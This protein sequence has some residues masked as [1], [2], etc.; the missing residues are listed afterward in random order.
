KSAP[1]SGSG[2]AKHP[3]A[4]RRRRFS[5]WSFPTL[6]DMSVVRTMT[7][8]F[9]FGFGAL[10]TLFDVFTSFELW[11]FLTAKGGTLKML[12]EYLFYL[13][14]LV[15]V[16]LFPASILVASLLHYSFIARR[17]GG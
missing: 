14:P 8:S 5:I 10:V 3:S 2:E 11:R 17:R 16:E 15:S 7:F 12:A 4:V 1:A 9:L 6:L 13:M